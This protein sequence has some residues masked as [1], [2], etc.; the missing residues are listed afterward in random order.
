MPLDVTGE[1]DIM[2]FYWTVNNQIQQI[3]L[4]IVAT[5][6]NGL[7][8]THSQVFSGLQTIMLSSIQTTLNSQ[9][10]YFGASLRNV[11]IA[12]STTLGVNAPYELPSGAA[13][14]LTNNLLP[15]Q[16][17]GLVAFTT[18]LVGRRYRGRVYLPT[19][20]SSFLTAGTGT[21]TVAYTNLLT[22]WA[23][24]MSAWSPKTLTSGPGTTTWTWSVVHRSRKIVPTPA[25]PP[26]RTPWDYTPITI[27]LTRFVFAT[28]RRSGALGRPNAAPF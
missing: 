7:G 5:S 1:I 13:G 28:Q 26:F 19:P 8:D 10:A 27:P 20:D 14:P 6:S 24:S 21:P 12:G 23:A 3:D 4:G 16:L 9:T 25:A 15:T 2:T 11:G 22:S 17:R 18:A